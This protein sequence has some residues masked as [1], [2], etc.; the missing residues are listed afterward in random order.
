MD[1]STRRTMS[2]DYVS[3][4]VGQPINS[5]SLSEGS[6]KGDNVIGKMLSVEVETENEE[7]LHLVI[8][9]LLPLTGDPDPASLGQAM[10][11][12]A[13]QVF[14]AELAY[15]TV[16]RP[17]L[18]QVTGL[19]QDKPKF[20]SGCSDGQNDYIALE[21]LRNQ[22]YKM[23]DKKKGLTL[24]QVL[25]TLKQIAAFHAHSYAIIESN[26]ETMN[27]AMSSSPLSTHI[28]GR[29]IF[30]MDQSI[31]FNSIIA[32]MVELLREIGEVETATKTE[33]F[34]NEGHKI[35]LDLWRKTGQNGTKYF[36]TLI[37]G[38][39][40]TNNILFKGSSDGEIVEDIAFIDFQQS[41]FGNIYE[42]LHYFI[43]TSTTADFRKT[44]LRTCL[45]TYFQEFEK[46]LQDLNTELPRGFTV[47][48]LIATFY[49]NI[50][51]G[52]IY[53]LVGIPFQLGESL[54]DSPTPGNNQPSE[55]GSGESSSQQPDV[56]KMLLGAAEVLKLGAKNSP[57]AI[58]RLKELTREMIKLN[59]LS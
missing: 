30:D 53:D 1:P 6:K 14:P 18:Q 45:Q 7:K 33:R 3:E 54:Q 36:R 59:V 10:F 19:K 25:S 5:F 41:R 12:T 42:E 57:I 11:V 38:D 9:S 15:Y 44:Y 51:Y 39:L 2:K 49:E 13:L 23:A 17:L 35:L 31:F 43:F 50:E 46:I 4:I 52:F 29:A 20:F 48:E 27:E 47:D 21:D 40:W 28:W 34:A 16:A 55:G 22:G 32:K 26:N 58:Q 37:H 24:Q 8:K 56:A